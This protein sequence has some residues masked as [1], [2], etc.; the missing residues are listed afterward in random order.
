MDNFK[1]FDDA[2]LGLGDISSLN[3]IENPMIHR[4]KNDIENPDLHL[5][6]LLRNPTYIG[7]TCKLIFNIELHPMQIAV[8]Q[9]IWNRPFPMLVGSRGFS[10]SFY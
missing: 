3:L 1:T 10:K 8:L 7:S 6:R 5:L 2:W 9:E 4:T